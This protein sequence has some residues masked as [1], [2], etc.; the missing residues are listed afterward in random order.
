[1]TPDTDTADN[2]LQQVANVLGESGAFDDVNFENGGPVIIVMDGY[3]FEV[4][5]IDN[6]EADLT[7]VAKL[8]ARDFR[9]S[10]MGGNCR[11]MYRDFGTASVSVCDH[12][13][14]AAP[15][16]SDWLIGAEDGDG[17]TLYEMGSDEGLDFDTALQTAINAAESADMEQSA[18]RRGDI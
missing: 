5:P 7:L 1:M 6:G 11:A 16:D 12:D 13:G 3:H 8:E 14:G 18:R 15:T 2:I 10:N 17:N 4:R 9:D